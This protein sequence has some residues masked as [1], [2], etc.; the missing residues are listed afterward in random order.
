[1]STYT[2][3]YS[4]DRSHASYYGATNIDLAEAEIKCTDI[5]S[6]ITA[7]IKEFWHK[8]KSDISCPELSHIEG[9]SSDYRYPKIKHDYFIGKRCI[10]PGSGSRKYSDEILLNIDLNHNQNNYKQQ[11]YQTLQKIAKLLTGEYNK[12]RTILL[13]C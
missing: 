3:E 2:K 7:F 11:Y 1:M 9:I 6:N 8:H 4:L 13:I 12:D 5:E 10:L